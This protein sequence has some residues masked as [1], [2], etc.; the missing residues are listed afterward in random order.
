MMSVPKVL[1]ITSKCPSGEIPDSLA[2]PFGLHLLR[3]HLKKNGIDCD[4][5]DHQLQPENLCVSDVEQGNYDIIGISV[6]HWNMASDLEFLWMLRNAAQKSGKNCLFIAGGFSATL[7]SSQW[8]ECGFDGIILGYGEETL[9]K[10]CE[11]FGDERVDHIWELFH[12]LDG[13]AFHNEGRQV[14]FNPA[15]PLSKS[16]FE[17]RMFVQTL[18]MDVPYNQYWEFMRQRATGILAM[19]RR[20]YVIENARLYTSSRCLANCGYCCCPAFLPTAQQSSAPVFMLS[21]RQVQQLIIHHVH[22]Y[23]ARAFSFNDED[24]LVGN[25]MGIN[26]AIELCELIIQSKQKGEIPEDTKFSCQTRVNDFLTLGSNHKKSVNR[27]LLK[28]MSQAGFHNV[29]IGVE[30]FSERLMKCPSVNKMRTTASDNCTVIDAMMEHGLYP[31]I[32]LILVIP[33]STPDELI[34]TIRQTLDYVDKP[35]QISVSNGMRAFPGAPIWDCEDYPMTG[36]MWTNPVTNQT[37]Y[38]PVYYTPLNERMAT[39]LSQL[40]NAARCELDN[41]KANNNWNESTLVP[42]ITISLCAFMTISRILGESE[43]LER[44]NNKLQQL[45]S[46]HKK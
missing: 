21:A 33:E 4:V 36:S 18:E 16:E 39:L 30:T 7:N 32:N 11:R 28:A 20:S 40:D 29:S 37:T 26:R 23:G 24:F 35:C 34:E 41:L 9:R 17:E 10:I 27:Q 5:F 38:I 43:L 42:R 25:R 19:N 2:I 12:E 3:H 1:L 14:V 15:K 8:L 31:T 6:T 46:Q 13:I 44:I 45:V 22:K